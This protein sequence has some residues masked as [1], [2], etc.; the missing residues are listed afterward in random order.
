MQVA[1]LN[2][3]ARFAAATHFSKAYGAAHTAADKLTRIT[4]DDGK[5]KQDT[6]RADVKIVVQALQESLSA[7]R[8][9]DNLLAGNQP[10]KIGD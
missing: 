5:L 1:E 7:A 6:T 3:P 4:T 10:P 8:A 9:L 2:L